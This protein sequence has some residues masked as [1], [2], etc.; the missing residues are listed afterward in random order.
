MIVVLIFFTGA[1]FFLYPFYINAL[2]HFI[3]EQRMEHLQ[4]TTEIE[5]KQK[6][7]EFAKKNA[8]IAKTG[9]APNG[10]DFEP[11]GVTSDIKELY[12]KHSIGSI[13]IPS[14]K[15]N[16]P[17]FD[18]TTAELLQIGAT[19]VPGTSYPTGGEGTHSMIAAHSG[20]PDRELFTNLEKVKIGDQFVLTVLD[21]KLAYEVDKII[22]VKP[23]ETDSLQ[24]EPGRD[25]VTL[26]TC[27][28][29]M[30]NTDRL[31]VTGHRVPYTEKLKESITKSNQDQNIKQLLII[32][33]SIVV[34]LIGIGLLYRSWYFFMLRKRKM[35]LALKVIDQDKN[36]VEGLELTLFDRKGKK[37]QKRN[38]EPFILKTNE[39]GEVCFEQI[40]HDRYTV[41]LVKHNDVS[42]VSIVGI[43]TLHQKNIRNYWKKSPYTLEIKENQLIITYKGS[44]AKF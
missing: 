24:I 27:T 13:S 9:L 40:P 32:A 31:L 18:T 16:I 44:V 15:V 2:N 42:K 30:V 33:G 14:I 39:K 41:F 36:P 23:E 25:I 7:A 35:D 26:I 34:T 37:Q 28:P 12:E 20:I 43:K 21:E 19:V 6:Q 38:K 1:L 4:K 17:L 10:V 3:D 11:V 29:Y 22:V 5:S 8:E